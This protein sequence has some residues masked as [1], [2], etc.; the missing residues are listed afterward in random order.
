MIQILD[1]SLHRKSVVICVRNARLTKTFKS[2]FIGGWT[3]LQ[4]Q[5]LFLSRS[6]HLDL[7]QKAEKF[8]SN[9][10]IRSFC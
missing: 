4:K 9:A 2:V 5:L 3:S 1:Y 7:S 8:L 6:V 10:W